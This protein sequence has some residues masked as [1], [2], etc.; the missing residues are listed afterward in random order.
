MSAQNEEKGKQV[1]QR[2][3]GAKADLSMSLEQIKREKKAKEAWRSKAEESEKEK[4]NATKF[5]DAKLPPATLPDT[6]KPM[7]NKRKAKMTAVPDGHRKKNR[8]PKRVG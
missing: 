4:E 8:R 7:N 5:R 3:Q 2:L 6:D 1:S